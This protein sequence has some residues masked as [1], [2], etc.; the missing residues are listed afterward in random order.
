MRKA[1]DYNIILL[2]WEGMIQPVNTNLSAVMKVNDVCLNWNG[3]NRCVNQ[4]IHCLVTYI[5]KEKLSCYIIPGL[6]PFSSSSFNNGST[7]AVIFS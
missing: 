6:E 5:V 7:F 1:L 2:F 4:T 3:M